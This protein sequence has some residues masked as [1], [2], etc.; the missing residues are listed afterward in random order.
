MKTTE[1]GIP[2]ELKDLKQWVLWK[3]VDEEPGK[4]PGKRFYQLDGRTPAK[5]N[6]STT[7]STFDEV[8]E[9]LAIRSGFEGHCFVIDEGTYVG[10][11]LDDCLID[12]LLSENAEEVVEQFKNTSYCEVSPSG[13]GLKLITRGKKPEGSA[14]GDKIDGKKWLEV[15]DFHRFWTFTGNIFEEA[16]T[17]GDG[18]ADVNWLADKYLMKGKPAKHVATATVTKPV[19]AIRFESGDTSLLLRAQGYV[20]SEPPAEEGGRNTQAFKLAG[21]IRKLVDENGYHLSENDVFNFVN[22]WNQQCKPPLD[23][24]ELRKA[25]R[26][27]SVHGTQPKDK[28]PKERERQ[29]FTSTAPEVI[30]ITSSTACEKT[31]TQE[32]TCTVGDGPKPFA[33]SG[34]KVID[35][36]DG[37][38]PP[39]LFKDVMASSHTTQCAPD[40]V[41]ASVLIAMMAVPGDKWI[42]LPKKNDPSFKVVP[43]TYGFIVGEPSDKKSPSLGLA[44]SQIKRLAA[45]MR[46]E[47]QPEIDKWKKEKAKLDAE[48]LALK[49][50]LKKLSDTAV[51]EEY[52]PS[53]ELENAEDGDPVFSDEP[54]FSLEPSRDPQTEAESCEQA[55][56]EE[57]DPISDISARMAAI[58]E[59]QNDP[60]RAREFFEEDAN[61]ESLETLLSWNPGAIIWVDELIGWLNS[62]DKK[63]YEQARSKFLTLWI[64]NKRYSVRRMNRFCFV[65]HPCVTVFGCMVPDSVRSLVTACKNG[66]GND[67]LLQ[68]FQIVV[69][70]EKRSHY[71]YVDTVGSEPIATKQAFDNL[72]KTSESA[73]YH[74]ES[75]YNFIQFSPEAQPEFAA[76]LTRQENRRIENKEGFSGSMI[77]HMGKYNSLVPS[78]AFTLQMAMKPDSTSIS[79][80]A[81]NYGIAW[82]EYRESHAIKMYDENSGPEDEVAAKKLL[83]LMLKKVGF[84]KDFTVRD[85]A[86]K[87]WVGFKTN[88]EAQAALETLR[89]MGWVTSSVLSVPGKKPT[90]Y[91]RLHTDASKLFHELDYH[92]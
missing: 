40:Y 6:D 21:H 68:R 13:K 39:G 63:G 38:L 22:Q 71:E 65:K 10:V 82:A 57:Y 83:G 29:S 56:E 70:P 52:S 67:G 46:E 84:D 26:N 53:E 30:E 24:R 85:V 91:Y 45:Q 79:L 19:G 32:V 74:E 18:Q 58:I 51:E 2:Q 59:L 16:N 66:S 9:A 78:I 20:D 69:W 41:G 47:K 12:G 50:R 92:S 88:S 77:A 35:F 17:I 42:I 60:P 8:G 1:M 61:M 3:Y 11:D 54:E 37:L 62:F 86:Q 15:Y 64:G 43:N 7:W 31:S 33:S 89:E 36:H 73:L 90:A 25:I 80:Q 34:I 14:S 76:W 23:E 81:L 55:T 75:D 27:S 48:F 4:K 72:T 44:E 49:N 28:P 5:T 87:R